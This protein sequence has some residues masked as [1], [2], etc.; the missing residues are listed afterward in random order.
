[1]ESSDQEHGLIPD[2]IIR[3]EFKITAPEVDSRINTEVQIIRGH[4]KGAG[5][6]IDIID[7]RTAVIALEGLHSDRRTTAELTDIVPL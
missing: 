1:L 2:S 6:V 4:N 3:D 7:N 5:R